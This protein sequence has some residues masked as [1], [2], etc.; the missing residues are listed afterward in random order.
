M[1]RR[2]GQLS[3]RVEGR[4]RRGH[5]KRAAGR[6][7]GGPPAEQGVGRG[8]AARGEVAWPERGGRRPLRA[9]ERKRWRRWLRGEEKET[10][11][12]R[13]LA[14][15]EGERGETG[16]KEC[17]DADARVALIRF[18]HLVG[19]LP[20]QKN[21]VVRIEVFAVRNFFAVRRGG[22]AVREVFAGRLHIFAV[23]LCPVPCG[24]ARQRFFFYPSY[25]SLLVTAI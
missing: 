14:G 21:F 24:I 23:R 12:T 8:E 17:R 2:G 19:T 18:S 7:R 9:D 6:V 25:I 5:A 3:R 22:I 4:G 1:A 13:R 16:W 10:A 20:W 11:A 15:E